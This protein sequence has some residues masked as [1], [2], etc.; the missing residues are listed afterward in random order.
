[1]PILAIY[2]SADEIIPVGNASRL[3]ELI[4]GA[5]IELLD[6]VGHM[7]WWEQP[8]RTAKLV[9]GFSSSGG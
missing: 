5:R 9:R 2:G 1:M 8:E 7:F 3:A 6:G 4:P